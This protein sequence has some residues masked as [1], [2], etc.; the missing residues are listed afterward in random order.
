MI[1]I[2]CFIPATYAESGKWPAYLFRKPG[3]LP[4]SDPPGYHIGA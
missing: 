1:G 4:S 3:Y 2:F